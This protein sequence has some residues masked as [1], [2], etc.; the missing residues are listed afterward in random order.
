MEF[1][2]D[3][4]EKPTHDLNGRKPVIGCFVDDS[5]GTRIYGPRSGLNNLCI[6]HRHLGVSDHLGPLG[7]TLIFA[8]QSYK[9][10]IYG[11][12]PT[13]RNNCSSIAIFKTKSNKELMGIAEEMGGFCT[14]EEFLEYYEMAM[15]ECGCG[16]KSEH[17][18]LFVDTSPYEGN[19]NFRKNLNTMLY[20]KTDKDKDK[21][22]LICIQE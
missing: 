8:T 22:T 7:C 2:S 5:L 11:I 10:N 17:N 21:K 16:C 18:I 9:S 12:S 19:S 6:L 15:N 1:G 3:L 13:I 14:P 4:L 20:L